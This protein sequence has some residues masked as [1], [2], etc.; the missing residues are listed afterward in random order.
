M[1]LMFE[2]RDGRLGGAADVR[3]RHIR[4]SAR[5]MRRAGAGGRSPG[6]EAPAAGSRAGGAAAR[7]ERRSSPRSAT[8]RHRSGRSRSRA[9]AFAN[10]LANVPEAEQRSVLVDAVV[11]M[12]LMAQAARDAGLDKGPEFEARLEF[13]TAAGA[14]QRL[15]RAER[16]ERADRR[17]AAG[18]LPDARR[19]AAQARGAGARAPHPRRHEGSGRED[20]RRSEGRRV[21]RGA[22]QA[23]EGSER[24]ERRRPRLLRPRPD[25]AAVRRRRPSRSS[26]ARSP[27]RRCRPSS[28]GTSSRSKRSG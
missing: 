25:G 24:P 14:A 22:G 7:P 17:G 16:R 13:L 27:R 20:H 23:V 15:C 6:S 3:R 5:R 18:G 26:P 4:R 2:D 19:R 8:D 9:E 12:K 11:N 10:E 21:V 1:S 28:A